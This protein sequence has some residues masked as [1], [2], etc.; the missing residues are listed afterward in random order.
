[1]NLSPGSLLIRPSIS[2]IPRIEA[3][4]PD[5]FRFKASISSKLIG[6][7]LIWLR[8]DESDS[9]KKDEKGLELALLSS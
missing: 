9:P 4:S 7:S 6:S 2:R 3:N 1:M 5:D 8:I